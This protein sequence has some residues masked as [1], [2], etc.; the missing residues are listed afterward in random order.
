[1]LPRNPDAQN[2]RDDH[3]DRNM[4]DMEYLV[5]P[6]NDSKIKLFNPDTGNCRRTIT[7]SAMGNGGA[8]Q[9]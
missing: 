7:S 8:L 3:P 6:T 5:V 2:Y 9:W 4:E 1:M